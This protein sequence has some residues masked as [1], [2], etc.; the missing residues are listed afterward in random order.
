MSREG[1]L[2]RRKAK[3]GRVLEGDQGCSESGEV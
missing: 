3:P 1:G 2:T